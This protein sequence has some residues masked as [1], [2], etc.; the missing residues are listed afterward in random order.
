[1]TTPAFRLLKLADF[2]KMENWSAS[3]PVSLKTAFGEEF[4]VRL[5]NVITPVRDSVTIE[6]NQQYTRIT[7]R[8]YGQGVF[9]RDTVLGVDI[10]TKKQFIAT[11][12][13][14]I[15]SGIDARNGSIGI[16]P[17]ELNGAIVTN[18]FWLFDISDKVV[19]QYLSLLLS[20]ER[21]Q[22]YW[23]SKSSGTTNRQRINKTEFLEMEIPLPAVSTQKDIIMN[24]NRLIEKAEQVEQKAQELENN[25]NNLIRVEFGLELKSVKLGEG[26]YKYLF[27]ARFKDT[28]DWSPKRL[29]RDPKKEQLMNLRKIGEVV[30]RVKDT[31]NVKDDLQY[32]RIT[33]K[34]ESRGVQV[35]DVVDGSFVQTK[36]QFFVKEGQ[37]AI[38]KIDA[39]NGAFGI[40]HS[41]ADGAI[42]TSNFWVFDVDT[43]IANADYLV[44]LFASSYFTDIWLECSN[45]SGNRLY[46]QEDE[47][48]N[49]EIP[50]PDLATQNKL[51]VSRK[52]IT[53]RKESVVARNHA[54]DSFDASVFDL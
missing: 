4:N 27:F 37:L 2:S 50:L 6:D 44:T 31:T 46:L 8:Q 45:G 23:Q 49:Y 1:M 40:V 51:A 38:S 43:K 16:V 47:F 22:Q 13:Q 34:L 11:E 39:R 29:S 7:I 20:S 15:V 17:S 41:D 52:I 24:F 32:K 14:L 12:G 48:L 36:K 33:I 25:V 3:L 26:A 5:A 19:P 10:G 21:F 18:D 30:K 35:R 9:P 42:I 54:R 53:Y 28:F